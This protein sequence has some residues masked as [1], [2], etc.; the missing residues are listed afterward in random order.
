MNCPDCGAAM[1]PATT[2]TSFHCTGC[3]SVH[4]PGGN[5]DG[6]AVVGEPGGVLCPVCRVPLVSARIEGELVC[7][8]GQCRG[9]LAD[10]ERFGIIVGKR[11]ALHGPNEKRIEPFDP[12]DL[13]RTIRCPNCEQRMDTHP[14]FGGGNVVVDTCEGCGLVWLD[15]GELAVI[16]RYI[17]HVPQIERTLTL[18]GGRFQGGPHDMPV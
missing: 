18:Y 2:I 5:A 6:I 15:A 17:P 10:T 1:E 16:E 11:R 13:Q 3:G 4:F 12:A 8:C 9:F 7:Y 14:Y